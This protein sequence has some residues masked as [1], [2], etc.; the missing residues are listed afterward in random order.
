MSYISHFST[1]EFF[2]KKNCQKILWIGT[3]AVALFVW[4]KTLCENG[5]LCFFCLVIL[6]KKMVQTKTNSWLL[7]YCLAWNRVIFIK[8]FWKISVNKG[9]QLIN[10]KEKKKKMLKKSFPTYSKVA[11]KHKKMR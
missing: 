3:L 11:T 8:L 7:L 1:I 2:R 4:R 6:G 10:K 9:S 5:L